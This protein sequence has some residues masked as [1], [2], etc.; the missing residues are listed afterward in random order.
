MCGRYV[1]RS[2]KQR[3][4]E[5]FVLGTLDDLILEAAP[6]YNI[7]PMTR[8]P[9]IVANR[10]TAN[11]RLAI[12]RWGQIPFWTKDVKTLGLSTINAKAETRF[13]SRSNL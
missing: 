9:V 12:M 4:A 6:S 1:R 2:D 10:D 8:Q 5:A 7:T 3:I 13:L 11:R